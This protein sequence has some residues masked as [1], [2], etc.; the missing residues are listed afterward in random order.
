MY[1]N[2]VILNLIIV[3]LIDQ[4]N[5]AEP[6]VFRPIWRLMTKLPYR[7]W[8][9]RPLSCSTCCSWWAGLIYIILIGRLSIMN[10]AVVLVISFFNFI[11]NDL[12]VIFRELWAKIVNK[13]IV[14]I[15]E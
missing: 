4:L 15:N 10:V 8:S 6:F 13:I 12:I 1:L 3:I 9:F 14:K 2:L 11:I 5:V 7:G